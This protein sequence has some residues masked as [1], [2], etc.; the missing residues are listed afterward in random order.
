VSSMRP[1]VWVMSRDRIHDGARGLL[2]L[3]LLLIGMNV[4]VSRPITGDHEETLYMG[5]NFVEVSGDIRHPGVYPFDRPPALKE[6]LDRAGGL[7]SRDR[8][9][10]PVEGSLYHSGAR[11]DVMDR[12]GKFRILEGDMSGFYRV[13]LGI[14][15]PVNLATVED[16]TAIPGLGPATARAIVCERLKRGRFESLGDILSVQGVGPALYKRIRPYLIL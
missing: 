14:P 7:L 15:V 2:L 8:R 12:A 3:L 11:V 6:L 5:E 1:L 13:T 10:F 4:L 9:Y 16:L